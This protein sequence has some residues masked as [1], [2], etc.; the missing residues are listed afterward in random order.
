[1]HERM[2]SGTLKE[3]ANEVISQ[4]ENIVKIIDRETKRS[5]LIIH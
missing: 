5:S 4:G 1:M 3:I 2:I